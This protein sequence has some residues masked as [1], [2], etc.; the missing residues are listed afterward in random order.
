M[1]RVVIEFS[2][3]DYSELFTQ[4]FCEN[5]EWHMVCRFIGSDGHFV[6]ILAKQ[7]LEDE[8]LPTAWSC[9]YDLEIEGM[10][11]GIAIK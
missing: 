8:V 7:G 9:I 1:K 11:L 2:S 4:A 6:T 10:V 3:S 5:N